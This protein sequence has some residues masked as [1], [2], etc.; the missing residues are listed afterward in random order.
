MDKC[1]KMLALF[2]KRSKL[3]YLN[4]HTKFQI[5]NELKVFNEILDD[6]ELVKLDLNN[7]IFNNNFDAYKLDRKISQHNCT[8]LYFDFYIDDIF[9]EINRKCKNVK[10]ENLS[11]FIIIDEYL[12]NP[13]IKDI[14]DITISKAISIFNETFDGS[15]INKKEYINLI[16][17]MI[18]DY[19]NGNTDNFTD[20]L[21]LYENAFC[22]LEYA[23][24]EVKDRIYI[25]QE[26][27]ILICKLSKLYNLE[28]NVLL[29]YI[30]LY[31]DKLVSDLILNDDNSLIIQVIKIIYR[32]TDFNLFYSFFPYFVE[33]FSPNTVNLIL[34]EFKNDLFII[35]NEN[36]KLIENLLIFCS[37]DLSSFQKVLNDNQNLSKINK[38]ISLLEFSINYL[39]RES[40]EFF[41]NKIVFDKD[42]YEYQDIIGEMK[43]IVDNF[44]RIESV[45][46]KFNNINIKNIDKLVI[47]IE[48]LNYLNRKVYSCATNRIYYSYFDKKS[49]SFEFLLI[50]INLGLETKVKVYFY[51]NIKYLD[52]N[53]KN[54]KEIFIQSNILF[55]LNYFEISNELLLKLYFYFKNNKINGNTTLFSYVI[56][57]LK[58]LKNML[59]PSL[60]NFNWD[61][62]S[63]DFE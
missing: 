12:N 25:Y 31:L 36:H 14:K 63:L 54:Q 21:L 11:E 13:R 15:F 10:F 57:E 52:I 8:N 42:Y 58:I 5:L 3:I 30:N 35:K 16:N 55:N 6:K 39:D 33:P 26:L 27:I 48:K 45:E 29:E 59:I 46:K 62:I 40:V 7:F 28:V 19:E 43:I 18:E 44:D 51:N 4:G 17:S 34:S 37:G 47:E 53:E 60:N 32:N 24:P 9:F 23:I 49:F 61:D 41:W 56:L 22:S 2:N 50:L 20:N 1:L 38:D